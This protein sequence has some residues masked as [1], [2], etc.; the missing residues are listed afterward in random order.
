MVVL[1]NAD[2]GITP[3][4]AQLRV[5]VHNTSEKSESLVHKDADECRLV[6]CG[7][8]QIRQVATA[9]ELDLSPSALQ[10]QRHRIQRK[11]AQQVAPHPFFNVGESAGGMIDPVEVEA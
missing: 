8:L 11:G 2:D 9:K 3:Q 4:D 6:A 7:F 10:R 1:Q 5:L